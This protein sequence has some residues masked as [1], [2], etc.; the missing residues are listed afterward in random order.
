MAREARFREENRERLLAR[1]RE[2]RQQARERY[3]AYHYAWIARRKANGGSFTSEEWA[4]LCSFYGGRCLAC[5]RVAKLTVDHVVP[6]SRGGS[7]DISNLQP[8]C[9]PCNS[10]KGNRRI[11]DYRP[12]SSLL[13]GSCMCLS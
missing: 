3:T 7:D 2:L 1:R 13:D 9:G 8:L 4:R 6:V 10:R 11:I 12:F 5:G